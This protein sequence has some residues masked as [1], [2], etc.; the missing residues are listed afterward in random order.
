MSIGRS[1]DATNRVTTITDALNQITT[2]TYDPANENL[3][4]VTAPLNRV[5]TI[6]YNSFGQPF[7]VQGSIATE[8]PT[9][10]AYDT[11]GNLI[12]VMNAKNQTA[13]YMYDLTD[14]LKTRADALNRTETYQYDIAA[15]SRDNE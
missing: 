5:T 1:G 13:T 9:I 14:R 6:A 4:T 7:S 15:T 3:L 2:F 12:T 11:N 8:P 10:F